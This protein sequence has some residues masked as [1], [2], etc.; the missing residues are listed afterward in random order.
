MCC[1]CN[2]R[3]DEAVQVV[4]PQ[5]FSF[6]CSRFSFDSAK[7]DCQSAQNDVRVVNKLATL[8]KDNSSA[9][10]RVPAARNDSVPRG[11]PLALRLGPPP[12]SV[13][14]R[15]TISPRLH[16][17]AQLAIKM[18]SHLLLTCVFAKNTAEYCT[19]RKF[20]SDFTSRD[21]WLGSAA[22][23]RADRRAAAGDPTVCLQTPGL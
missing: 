6:Y 4:S 19:S 17:R 14:S 21:D 1:E 11:G 20:T 18:R 15:R 12:V 9:A 22:Y 5:R 16:V 10:A 23:V 3:A 8:K 7:L 2:R 13:D